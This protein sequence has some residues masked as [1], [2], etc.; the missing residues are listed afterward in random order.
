MNTLGIDYQ[1]TSTVI[2][3]REG[4][5]PGVRLRSISDGQRR[6]IPNAV[7]GQQT[8][9]SHALLAEER[10]GLR[11][12]DDRQEGPWLDP[13]GA[14]VFWRAL[15]RR[16]VAYLGG[17]EPVP[18]NGYRL[19]VGF[20]AENFP[21]AAAAVVRLATAAGFADPV[22]IPATDALLCR[23]LAERR[24]FDQ[25]LVASVVQ[26]DTSTTVRAYR[27]HPG[28]AGR[29]TV[30]AAGAITTV[31][32]AGQAA[33]VRR[34]TQLV[35]DRLGGT[36][37]AED[38]LAVREAAVEFGARLSQSDEHQAVAWSG[39]LSERM[40]EPVQTTRAASLALPEIQA[41]E[42]AL[43]AALAKALAK[44]GAGD[45][46]DL[47]LRGGPGAV[48]P[49]GL[50]ALLKTVPAKRIWQ[51]ADPAQDVAW[52]AAWWPETGKLSEQVLRWSSASVARVG[53]SVTVAPA[54]QPAIAEP[55]EAES[56]PVP[57][58]KRKTWM[59]V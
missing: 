11:Q 24:T 15:F 57:P 16:A 59:D 9:G 12:G 41:L 51:S 13:A 29:A 42:E 27:L 33:W 3:L 25:H 50:N 31:P 28:E 56:A 6:L 32:G 46:P 47:V 7:L 19:V 20:Q 4:D 30:T 45:Q 58:W 8:W 22:C 21:V 17:L 49:F 14:P 53:P 40:L 54:P 44:T 23:W 34:I 48:W 18:T 43:G 37:P 55:S 26:G 5:E 35:S 36:I 10:G 39:P 2:A 52:G 1:Q 38:E